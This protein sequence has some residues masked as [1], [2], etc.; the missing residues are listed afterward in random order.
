[1]FGDAMNELV[2]SKRMH[3]LCACTPLTVCTA[4]EFQSLEQTEVSDRECTAT[5]VCVDGVEFEKADATAVSDRVCQAYT[6]CGSDF[7]ETTAPTKTTDRVCTPAPATATTSQPDTSTPKFDTFNRGHPPWATATTT[8]TQTTTTA[9]AAAAATA[10]TASMFAVQCFEGNLIGMLNPMKCS[11]LAR[12]LN[13]LLHGMCAPTIYAEMDGRG[14]GVISCVSSPNYSDG[15]KPLMHLAFEESRNKNNSAKESC[16]STARALN[17]AITQPPVARL[18]P[19]FSCSAKGD[20]VGTGTFETCSSSVS[21]LNF[22][23]ALYKHN[24]FTGCKYPPAAT[25]IDGVGVGCD[26]VLNSGLVY[27]DCKVCNGNGPP[28]T[29]TVGTAT[30]RSTLDHT[31]R[32]TASRLTKPNGSTTSVTATTTPPSEPPKTTSTASASSTTASS[33][34]GT[35][36][37]TTASSTTG[38][39]TSTTVS[40]TT[41]SSTAGT[42][43]PTHFN[44]IPQLSACTRISNCDLCT[45]VCLSETPRSTPENLECRNVMQLPKQGPRCSKRVDTLGLVESDDDSN[46]YG[47]E[48]ARCSYEQEDIFGNKF[49]LACM[50]HPEAFVETTTVTTERP[51]PTRTARPELSTRNPDVPP[52]VDQCQGILCALDC[53]GE[54]CGWDSGSDTCVP[55]A[56]TDYTE[57][58]RGDC[59][60]YRT[61]SS[62]PVRVTMVT[63]VDVGSPGSDTVVPV[64]DTCLVVGCVLDCTG[65]CGWNRELGICVSGGITDHAELQARL[66]DC[67]DAT[68]DNGFGEQ[69]VDR[70]VVDSTEHQAVVVVSIVVLSIILLALIMHAVKRRRQQPTDAINLLFERF[71]LLHANARTSLHQNAGFNPQAQPPTYDFAVADAEVEEEL[72]RRRSC[73]APPSMLWMTPADVNHGGPGPGPGPGPRVLAEDHVQFT[74][75]EVD[76][77]AV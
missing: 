8:T 28:C 75:V 23:V 44:S 68:A 64:L 45:D 13:S 20:I 19:L 57:R 77:G 74:P 51:T 29:T 76:H 9:T 10:T 40:S 49:Y 37:T 11:E 6:E 54:H 4:A 53:G 14:G 36:T 56:I 41:V 59:S 27:D 33:T 73:S 38:T 12:V 2:V 63:T 60:H 61:T 46:S 34:T 52:I 16:L 18:G 25:S 70:V 1:M 48:V 67:P 3:V 66:G 35:E 50:E 24:L 72:Q 42:T 7:T 47:I 31:Y 71:N 58:L 65:Q 5:T 30:P 21:Y 43:R 62:E 17:V 32:T 55:G 26:G 69:S 15:V 22:M 39:K